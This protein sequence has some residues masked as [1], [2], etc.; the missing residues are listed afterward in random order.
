MLTL[1]ESKKGIIVGRA[2]SEVELVESWPRLQNESLLAKDGNIA[3]ELFIGF[4]LQTNLEFEVVGDRGDRFLYQGYGEEGL[5][6]FLDRFGKVRI[7][8]H[9]TLRQPIDFGFDRKLK[10]CWLFK[11]VSGKL[12]E[13]WPETME[14]EHYN[15]TEFTFYQHW[16]L[17]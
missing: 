16:L 3:L 4:L 15:L 17:E 8:L 10:E 2:G 11:L 6:V 12:S 7:D 5:D 1:R 9:E 13:V 14:L